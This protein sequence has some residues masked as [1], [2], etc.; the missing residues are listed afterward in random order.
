MNNPGQGTRADGLK[1]ALTFVWKG[2]DECPGGVQVLVCHDEIVVEYDVEQAEE[3]KAWLESAMVEAMD[4]ILNSIGEAHVPVE[5]EWRVASS[6]GEGYC[7][8]H[9]Y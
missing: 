3:A 5:V 2:R 1:L 4:A 6:W 7:K 9:Y 8:L